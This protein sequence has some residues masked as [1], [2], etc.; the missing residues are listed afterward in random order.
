M[1]GNFL[2]AWT[3]HTCSR[4]AEGRE[5]CRCVTW[6]QVDWPGGS[7]V[8]P[9]CCTP[10]RGRLVV[11]SV[12]REDEQEA[13]TGVRPG[14]GQSWLIWR[15][16]VGHRGQRSSEGSKVAAHTGVCGAMGARG[17][18]EGLGSERHRGSSSEGLACGATAGA[19][20]HAGVD[21][22]LPWLSPVSSAQ[23]H[24]PSLTVPRGHTWEQPQR[25]PSRPRAGLA[26]GGG[27]DPFL[28]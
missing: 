12:S 13:E 17:G 21:A 18:P 19:S 22:V 1:S 5:K 14:Q 6:E 28:P 11:A 2:T 3:Y 4:S 20:L 9:R 8:S 7:V 26:P 25:K 15:Q 16:N 23:F 27:T 24:C 10:L